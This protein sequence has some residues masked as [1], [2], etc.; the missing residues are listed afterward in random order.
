MYQLGFLVF[1][2]ASW[3]LKILTSEESR[4]EDLGALS[5]IYVA[6]CVH[7]KLSCNRKVIKNKLFVSVDKARKWEAKYKLLYTWLQSCSYI[8]KYF[9]FFNIFRVF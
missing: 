6:F 5:A 8:L 9:L 7:L 1:T 4:F 3:R 2:Y